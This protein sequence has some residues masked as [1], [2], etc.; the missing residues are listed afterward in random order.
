MASPSPTIRML[1]PL[2]AI[3]VIIGPEGNTLKQLS[4][5][6]AC[7]IEFEEPIGEQCQTGEKILVISGASCNQVVQVYCASD[8]CLYIIINTYFCG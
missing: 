7:N 1:L 6:T 3:D 4:V 2:S 8:G 5:S